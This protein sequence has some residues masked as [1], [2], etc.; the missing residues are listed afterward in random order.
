MLCPT[1]MAVT[2][3]KKGH[4]AAEL[5]MWYGGYLNDYEASRDHNEI[6][7]VCVRLEVSIQVPRQLLP[8][9]EGLVPGWQMHSSRLPVAVELVEDL[10]GHRWQTSLFNPSLYC[11]MA[12]ATFKKTLHYWFSNF[13][14]SWWWNNHKKA[15]PIKQGF[16][17]FQCKFKTCAALI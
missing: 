13:T 1:N 17:H 9:S 7:A 2:T 4:I 15:I 8:S 3:C 14:W 12:Q 16:V 6:T 10:S 5:H 11:P